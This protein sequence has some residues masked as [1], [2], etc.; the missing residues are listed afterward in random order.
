MKVIVLVVTHL[1][2]AAAGF[3][4][5]IY[6][7]PIL[8]APPPPTAAEVK[9]AVV[10]A[11]YT[12][13]FRRDLPGS[14]ALHWG[15]GRVTVGSQRIAFEGRLAPG[16]DYKVYLS[17]EYVETKADF[18]RVKPRMARVADVKTFENFVVGV[19]AASI[20]PSTRPSSS[21]ARPSVCSSRPPPTDER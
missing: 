9:S 7:L 21:G 14:D 16:P 3:A 17:P 10:G 4:L 5:G 8:I 13:T 12:G 1:L 6:V 11:A 15:E 18:L 19:P 2:A 20:P